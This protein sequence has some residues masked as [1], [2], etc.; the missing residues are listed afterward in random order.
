[1]LRLNIY[2]ER[3]LSNTS[4]LNIVFCLKKEDAQH[5]GICIATTNVRTNALKYSYWL[6]ARY[7]VELKFDVCISMRKSRTQIYRYL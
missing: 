7:K 6:K 4:N 2:L 5:L 3:T 1:M